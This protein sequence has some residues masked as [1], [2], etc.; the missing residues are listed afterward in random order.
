[1]FDQ[2]WLVGMGGFFGAAARYWVNL[3]F[4]KN[5]LFPVGTFIVNTTGSFVL[6]LILGLGSDWITLSASLLI[7]TGFLGA[8][9]TFSTFNFELFSLKKNKRGFLF[10]LYLVSS[11]S[12]GILFAGLGFW[13]GQ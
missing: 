1:M 7:G 3:T 9:T 4:S 6:G 13:I 8:Y 12:F 5:K 11:Y 2:I 10:L